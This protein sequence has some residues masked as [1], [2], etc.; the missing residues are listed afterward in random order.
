MHFVMWRIAVS[1]TSGHKRSAT[2][3]TVTNASTLHAFTTVASLNCVELHARRRNVRKRRVPKIDVLTP[4]AP[5]EL[6][7]MSRG[8]ADVVSLWATASIQLWRITSRDTRAADWLRPPA[9]D[10]RR[11]ALKTD[12][13]AAERD[14]GCGP[15]TARP[16]HLTTG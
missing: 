2:Y 12:S 9:L 4:R 5:N 6:K 7:R 3:S 16:L 1:Q 13:D 15:Y 10:E 14:A 8:S 11:T